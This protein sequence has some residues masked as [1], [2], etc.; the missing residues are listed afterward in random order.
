[1][2]YRKVVLLLCATIMLS[3]CAKGTS[4]E[5][6]TKEYAE[7]VAKEA[8]DEAASKINQAIDDNETASKIKDGA[9]T[10]GEYAQ[11]AYDYATDEKTIN[12]AKENAKELKDDSVNFVEYMLNKIA[13]QWNN[14]IASLEK[15]GSSDYPANALEDI[16][17]LSEYDFYGSYTN[18]F[19]EAKGI[20]TSSEG[21]A[22][23]QLKKAYGDFTQSSKE[24]AKK[25]KE[26]HDAKHPK[27]NSTPAA[28]KEDAKAET[29]TLSAEAEDTRTYTQKISDLLYPI[30]PGYKGNTYCIVNNNIPFFDE[31]DLTTEVF[32]TYSELDGLGRCGVAYAN[33]CKE[34]MPTE[35]RQSIGDVRPTGFKQ[36]RYDCLKTEE[37]PYGYLYARC[38]LIGFQLAGENANPQNLISG[39]FYFNVDGMEP[40]ENAV[41][42]YVRKT[43]RHVLYRVTPIYNGNSLVANGVLMEARSVEDDEICFCIYVYNVAP[44]VNIDY[45]TGESALAE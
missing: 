23:E 9:T 17:N 7:Q 44:G 28:D 11:D 19:K 42:Q 13:N 10:A 36:K 26:N 15:G 24:T 29:D 25:I 6:L 5:E 27:S 20:D 40:F 18:P 16:D 30:I 4:A 12:G 2:K 43:N 38:H 37:N 3:G 33:I 21:T 8:A 34:I 32:E 14:M 35:E 39:S 45:S 22:M 41:A 31:E 1:M